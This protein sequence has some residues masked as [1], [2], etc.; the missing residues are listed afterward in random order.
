MR[1]H[2]SIIGFGA[3]LAG[4]LFVLA[5]I[6]LRQPAV[7]YGVVADTPRLATVPP[8]VTTPPSEPTV[9]NASSTAPFSEEPPAILVQ[10]AHL[11]TPRPLK[12]VY[13]TSWIA[14]TS[15]L[16]ERVI[17][18]LDRTEA[19]AVV[20][21][22]K[23]D[24][25]KISFAVSDPA[26]KAV[27]SSESR[28]RGLRELLARLH[29]KGIYTIARIAVF[30]DPFLAERKQHL[31]V[32]RE[33]DGTVWRDR[34]GL[35]WIDPSAKEVW[36]YVALIGQEA[37]TLGFDEINFDYVR[38][39]SDGNLQDISYPISKDRAR[40]VVMK[41]FFTYI[42]KEFRSRGIPVSVD[43]F[44][45]T[46]VETSD[47]G[48]GQLLEDALPH[49][50]YI[51]PMVYPSHYADG[52]QGY[53]NP[54]ENPYE[55]VR[56]SMDS[57]VARARTLEGKKNGASTTPSVGAPACALCNKLRPW[58][59]DFDLGADYT[60]EMI[61]AQIQAVED[62]GL[63]SWMLWDPSNQYTP[64]GLLDK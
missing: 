33:S 23:D 55:I 14:G 41:E 18:L 26:L 32:Q 17:N 59:Q 42:G 13:M 24:T 4:A 61:R 12:A 6:T 54:A 22:V 9:G 10:S 38:F 44:G 40:T 45:L 52:F 28:I 1:I 21:D 62:A 47:L 50:D 35:S 53:A 43:L 34:K 56:Y 48:I 11:A 20:I 57:A 29:A 25:G 64:G 2:G 39:P 19:N 16:R 27:G 49:F 8:T 15:H 37:Y 30:Q 3:A 58:L 46:T 31:A 5:V 51:A 63:D 60:A 7:E 36:D